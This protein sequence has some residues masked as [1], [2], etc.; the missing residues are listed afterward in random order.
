LLLLGGAGF[1]Y[2]RYAHTPHE[3]AATL[4]AESGLAVWT[5][6]VDKQGKH[7]TVQGARLSAKPVSYSYELWAWPERGKPVSLGQLPAG[8]TATYDLDPAQSQAL[9]RS[10]QV[11]VTVEVRGSSLTGRRV[12]LKAPLQGV[13]LF[14]AFSGA[15]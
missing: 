9:A 1:L 10:R 4:R 13:S 3:T 12:I 7:V 6:K 8:G 15:S 2:W 5:V 14:G 11:A